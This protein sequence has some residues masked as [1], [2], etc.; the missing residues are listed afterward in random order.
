MRWWR[1]FDRA[2]VEDDFAR[3]GAAGFDSVRIFLL[4]EHFQP[5]PRAVSK[6]GLSELAQVADLASAHGLS[7]LVTLFTGHM[8]GVNWIPGWL[9]DPSRSAQRFRIVAGDRVVDAGI[10]N[11]YAESSLIEAQA[12]LAR[13]VAALLRDHPALWAW[14]LGNESSNCV[15]PPSRKAAREWLERVADAI[16]S[17]DGRHPITL[18]LHL[19]DLEEDR[20]LGPAEAATV[21]DFL[22]MHGYPIYTPWAGSTTEE[23]LLPFL[24]LVTEWLGGREVLFEEF[25]APALPRETLNRL[26]R[27]SLL[28]DEDEAGAFMERASLALRRFGFP[29]ALVWCYGDYDERLWNEPPFDAII[30]E[31]WFGL[32]RADGSPK[33]AV[34]AIKKATRAGAGIVRPSPGWIDIEREE[35]Y[36]RPSENL[37]RLYRRFRAVTARER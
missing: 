27:P 12:R 36:A 31:R 20:R 26:G 37:R 25:G 1:R 15:I 11:W 22:S 9:L 4:W 10:R 34:A 18:G 23:L 24:G 32:W 3:I 35:Y 16:R 33:P 7:L 17:V 2:E 13:E 8:S 30:H 6:E 19:E 21:C 29:G 5:E 28:L 14:D